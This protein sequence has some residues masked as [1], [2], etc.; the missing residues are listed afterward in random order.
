[1]QK[2]IYSYLKSRSEYLLSRIATIECRLSASESVQR[3]KITTYKNPTLQ[4]FRKD[5]IKL[6]AALV[7]APKRHNSLPQKVWETLGPAKG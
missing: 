2:R 1:M 4:L 7:I 5:N 3:G 6:P